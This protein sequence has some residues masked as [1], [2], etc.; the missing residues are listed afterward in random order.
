MKRFYALVVLAALTLVALPLV[1][2]AADPSLAGNWKI[3]INVNGESHESTCTFKQDSGKLTGSCK[4]EFGETALTGQIDGDKISWKHEVPY[5]GE[6]LVLTYSGTL[7]SATEIKGG[8]NV[9]PYDIAGDF[10][11]TKEPPAAEKP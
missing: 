10:A 7:S 11:G 5:N 3:T 9:Q 6:T 2:L 8:V 4:G 1:V